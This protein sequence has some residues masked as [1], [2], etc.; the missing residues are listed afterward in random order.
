MHAHLSSI[1]LIIGSDALFAI[2]A[3]CVA[4]DG[5]AAALI[6]RYAN[7]L[8]VGAQHKG[9]DH[10]E[11]TNMVQTLLLPLHMLLTIGCM[12]THTI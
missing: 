2:G 5:V 12:T 3:C 1:G 8:V 10:C 9:Q 11:R 7:S 4:C 6:L